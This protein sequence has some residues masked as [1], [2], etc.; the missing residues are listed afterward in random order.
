MNLNSGSQAYRAAS[1]TNTGTISPSSAVIKPY[2]DTHTL[3]DLVSQIETPL[4]SLSA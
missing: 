2:T 4:K 1:A 3:P